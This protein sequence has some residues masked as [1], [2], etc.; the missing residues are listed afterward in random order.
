MTFY[1]R[2][3]KSIMRAASGTS[4]GVFTVIKH[5]DSE[6]QLHRFKFGSATYQLCDCS[7]CF[8]ISK[9]GE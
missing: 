6:V 1:I 9:L 8:Y 3:K 5:M 7:L 2:L 4:I